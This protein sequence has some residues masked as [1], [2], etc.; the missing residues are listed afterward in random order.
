VAA[1]AYRAG[2]KLEDHRTAMVF[3]FT[4]RGGVVMAKVVA[5]AVAGDL[6]FDRSQ[7]W[8]AA[9]VAEKRKDA[10]TAREWILA[11]PSELNASQRSELALAFANE[12]VKRYGVI[13]DL[14]IHEPSKNGDERNHHAHLLCTTRSIQGNGFGEKA[15]LELSDAKRK[16]LGLCSG[17]EEIQQL[18]ARWADLANQ[19]LA[20]AGQSVR[21]DH[22]SLIDQQEAALE[23]GDLGSAFALD[24]PAQRHV[25]VHATALDRRSGIV[26]SERGVRRAAIVADAHKRAAAAEERIRVAVQEQEEAARRIVEATHAVTSWA[27][28]GPLRATSGPGASL[29]W[30]GRADSGPSRADFGPAIG[31]LQRKSIGWVEVGSMRAELGAVVPENTVKGEV[32]MHEMSIEDLTQEIEHRERGMEK[33]LDEVPELAGDRTALKELHAEIRDLRIRKDE[34]DAEADACLL[35]IDTWRRQHRWRA[36]FTWVM[37]SIDLAKLQTEREGWLDASAMGAE[38]ISAKSAQARRARESLQPLEGKYRPDLER[39]MALDAGLAC[40]LKE[41][42][43]TRKETI[44][45]QERRLALFAA[46]RVQS[47]GAPFCLQQAYDTETRA[48]RDGVGS[49]DWE[50]VAIR[51]AA[52]ALGNG[53][54]PEDC[55]LALERFWP[56]D[57]TSIPA[58]IVQAK[59]QRI[60]ERVRASIA[61][62]RAPLTEGGLLLVALIIECPDDNDARATVLQHLEAVTRVVNEDLALRDGGELDDRHQAPEQPLGG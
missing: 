33:R 58:L 26:M 8:N 27:V 62:G 56:G 46:G 31:E 6:A 48:N 18:R 57:G 55:R 41:E 22:R 23:R 45:E 3:D 9:E 54:S 47:P 44:A 5:P 4:R 35:Q 43:S 38:K 49:V 25:G 60:V 50:R 7:I 13:V 37:K 1:A 59:A 61:E 20:S 53:N 10:R 16:E 29:A 24:R 28:S 14:A 40:R 34:A 17:A 19:A 36:M 30:P 11:L 42:L 32:V 51:G 52:N 21:I 15:A 12:L 2:V 39:E